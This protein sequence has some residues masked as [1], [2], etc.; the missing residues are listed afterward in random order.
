MGL[1]FTTV[2]TN[3]YMHCRR[4]KEHIGFWWGKLREGDHLE[5]HTLNSR[6]ILKS[7]FKKCVGGAWTGSC[8]SG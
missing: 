7:I 3:N 1:L 4:G 2:K 6:I 5:D 8:G